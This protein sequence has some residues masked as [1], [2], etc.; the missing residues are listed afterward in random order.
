MAREIMSTKQVAEYFNCSARCA[1]NIMK[2]IGLIDIGHGYVYKDALEAYVA[3][4]VEHT[5]YTMPIL[6]K[7]YPTKNPRYQRERRTAQ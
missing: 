3:K 4:M 1:R 7:D 5:E 6:Q 2:K